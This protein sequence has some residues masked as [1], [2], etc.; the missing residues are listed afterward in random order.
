MDGFLQD[1]RAAT[2]ALRAR[3][4][5][6]AVALLT[7]AIGIGA[8]TAVFSLVHAVLLRALPYAHP[9]E[10]YAV[11]VDRTD[12]ARE[13][14]SIADYLDLAGG[15]VVASSAAYAEG[16]VS[17][18]GDGDPERLTWTRAG[19]G[20]FHTLGVRPV[21]G[22]I[23]TAEEAAAGA[24][25][26]VLTDALWR[27]R[28][29][30]DPRVL[31]R[32]LRLG[33]EPH[34]VIGVLPADYL[35]P[36]S[37]A[38]LVV[39]FDLEHDRRRARR[40]NAFLRVVARVPDAAPARAGLAAL[41]ARLAAEHPDT[42]ARKRG[43]AL[44]P[45]AEELVGRFRGLL[46]VL[47]AAVAVVQLV[48][49]ANLAGLLLAAAARRRRELGLRV[50]LG[51]SP[52][53]LARQLLLESA[54][55][56]VAGAALGVLLAGWGV[57]LLAAV[58][59]AQL[60]RLREA[61]LDGA[62]LAFTAAVTTATVLLVGLAPARRAAR[63]APLGIALDDR[64]GP[65][66]AAA[67]ARRVLVAAE[68][69]LSVTLLVVA[70]LLVRSFAR[71]AAVDPG[72]QPARALT[73]RLSVP[74][75]R[76]GDRAAVVRF[77]SELRARL[78]ALPG[79]VE[80]ASI[81]ALPLSGVLSTVDFAVDG[82][83]APARADVPQLHYRMVG[84]GSFTALGV[85]LV[86]GRDFTDGDG[87]EAPPVVIVNRRLAARHLAG[88]DPV[89]ARLFLD[90]GGPAPRRV[91]VVGVAGDVRD[92]GLDSDVQPVA[93]V[94]LAQVPEP[95]VT[96]ARNPFWVVRTTG[97][98]APLA[99][100]VVAAVHDVDPMMPASQ[101]RT[102]EEQVATSLAPRLFNLRLVGAFAT[103]ALALAALGIGALTSALV[104]ARRRELGVRLA[105]GAT[106]RALV[107][108]ALSDG[109]RPV[110]VGLAAGVAAALAAARLARGLL[111]GVGPG[112]PGTIALAVALL[113][114]V[115]VVAAW[116]PACRAA[117]T[118]PLTALRSD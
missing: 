103:L 114:G 102:L 71:L 31:G 113:L 115:S 39:P 19:A 82:A 40:D 27:R 62:V 42:N 110:V 53:R 61:R 92:G 16:G 111:Y 93:Y 105:L 63:A 51:A 6:T 58:T 37:R 10:L 26:V 12:G 22:R 41:A 35:G 15:G 30:G 2:R 118:D 48:T 86:A 7:L 91:T 25:V 116:I 20:F 11:A 79:V 96:Y 32:T 101:L 21:L 72:F 88:R 13:P 74:P 14:L 18:A 97:T 47:L 100:A 66:P 77:S 46:G 85:P 57:E 43:F 73:L 84:P 5:L 8:N 65:G 1:L 52:R 54:L 69:A 59:P 3:P 108:F 70:G 4:G 99:R 23:F 49:C 87:P 55:L 67:R 106:S 83:P 76:Y 56:A 29:A 34:E 64:A 81:H 95:A 68:V 117:R 50:A 80:A 28:Y 94:P 98:P 60:P 38:D 78:R 112:D 33:D 104:T 44:T 24:R 109:L 17:L 90:D 107:A 89:G 36:S 9:A 75:S 45:L